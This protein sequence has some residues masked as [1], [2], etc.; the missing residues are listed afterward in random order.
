MEKYIRKIGVNSLVISILL[1]VLSLFMMLKTPETIGVIIIMFG[2]VLVVNGL[3]HFHSYLAIND[4]YR[5]FSYELAEAIIDTIL[6]FIVV[7]NVQSIELYLQIVIGIWIV[8]EGILKVQIALNIRAVRNVKW[9][10]ML[11]LSLISIALGIAIIFNPFASAEILMKMLG[12]VLFTTQLINIYDDCYVLLTVK[13]VKKAV[14]KV[15]T[16]EEK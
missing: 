13:E 10:M 2:F 7:C 15:K 6:G 12:A 5:Y 8:L 14:K 4:D 9:G 1:S 11:L 3:I 16:S